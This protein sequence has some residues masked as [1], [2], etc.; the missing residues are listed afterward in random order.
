MRKSIVIFLLTISFGT[1][2]QSVTSYQYQFNPIPFNPAFTGL[3]DVFTISAQSRFQ[4]LG[5]QGAPLSQSV[6]GHSRIPGQNAALGLQFWNMSQGVSSQAGA[7]GSYAYIIESEDFKICAGIRAGVEFSTIDYVSLNTRQSNDPSF[8][9]RNQL[10]LPNVGIGIAMTSDR[11]D[12]G[13]SIP[14]MI[15]SEEQPLSERQ[16]LI[17]GSYTFNLNSRLSLSPSFFARAGDSQIKEFVI[18]S[19]LELEDVIGAAVFYNTNNQMATLLFL[20]ATDQLRIAYTAEFAIAADQITSFGSHE[21]GIHY[22][23]RLPQRNLFSPR[24]F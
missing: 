10:I 23:F 16:Y 15:E 3:Y 14:G 5:L 17:Q 20:N 21:L 7:F 8:S 9:E 11:F 6:T 24:Y 13:I 2:A 1:A 22:I 12:V 18:G 19:L 4:S